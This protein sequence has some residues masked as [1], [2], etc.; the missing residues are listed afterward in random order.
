MYVKNW[1]ES[2][3][4]TIL[5]L[6]GFGFQYTNVQEVTF[7]HF[8]LL[9]QLHVKVAFWLFFTAWDRIHFLS[10][11]WFL[12]VLFCC[13]PLQKLSKQN[14][15]LCNCHSLVTDNW[16]HT[17]LSLTSIEAFAK[18][19]QFLLD[20]SI[21]LWSSVDCNEDSNFKVIWHIGNDP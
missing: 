11:L 2:L 10:T 1:K 6:R 14:V 13:T 9:D 7:F 8:L 21:F 16:H 17:F 19:H 5:F 15:M 12:S 3:S 4:L 20:F 18:I